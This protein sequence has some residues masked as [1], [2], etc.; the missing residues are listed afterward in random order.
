[1]ES[2]LFNSFVVLLEF[3]ARLTIGIKIKHDA[4]GVLNL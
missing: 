2:T 3:F 4:V 1:M